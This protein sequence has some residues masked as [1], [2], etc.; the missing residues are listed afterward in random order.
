MDWQKQLISL[1]LYVCKQ[2]Q[3]KLWVINQRMANHSNLSFS[4]EEVITLYLFGVIDGNRTIKKI[5]EYANR[6]LRDWFPNLPSYAGYVYRLNKVSGVF[7]AIL[8][9]MQMEA[10][11]PN[12]SSVLLIDS[13]PVVMAKQGRRFNAKVAPEIA[14]SGYCSTKKLYFYGVKIHIAGRYHAGTLPTPEYIGMYGAADH[15]GK[16]FDQIRP[17]MS[18]ETVFGDKAYARPDA[19]EAKEKYSVSVLT[20]V[21]KKKGQK[22]LDAADQW[23]SKAVSSVRQPIESIFNWLEEKT[24]IE[25]ASK[26]RSYEGLLVHVFGRL[27]AAL[28]YWN[29]LRA[30]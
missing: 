27:A 15:D 5:Y 25:C 4:D 1:Y 6:H 24:G 9:E 14:S 13:F 7:S 10:K 12:N 23:L 3:G 2:Y 16:V 29:R 18:G 26:V 21:K 17:E 30:A 11:L 8:D 20:P 28:F 19:E 22:Y